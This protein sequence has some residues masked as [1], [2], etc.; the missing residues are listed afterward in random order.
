[1]NNCWFPARWEDKLKYKHIN[2]REL[3]SIAAANFYLGKKL[4]EQGRG[5]FYRQQTCYTDME[6]WDDGY[7]ENN[8]KTVLLFGKEE[9]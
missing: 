8:Q 5:Y 7:D 9:C 6:V 4:K 1:M 3:F 2:I